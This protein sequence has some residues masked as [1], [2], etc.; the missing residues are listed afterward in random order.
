[1]AGGNRRT[2]TAPALVFAALQTVRRIQSGAEASVSPQTVSPGWLH[3]ASGRLGGSWRLGLGVHSVQAS[4]CLQ[5]MSW[6]W[7][8]SG[9]PVSKLQPAAGEITQVTCG[10]MLPAGHKT[11]D[12][13]APVLAPGSC[14]R[15]FDGV[16]LQ[17]HI[18][19][20][21]RAKAASRQQSTTVL[22]VPAM[23]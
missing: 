5:T 18:C 8:A 22:C 20:E 16:R 9:Q 4:A 14:I 13:T 15:R 17:E 6:R 7:F 10:T 2:R 23:Q 1:M 3:A 11:F 12:C 19:M 21:P